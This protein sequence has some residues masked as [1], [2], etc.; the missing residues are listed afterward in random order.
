MKF[1]NDWKSRLKKK[2]DDPSEVLAFLQFLFFKKVLISWDSPVGFLFFI[3][4]LFQ[5]TFT[6]ES[7]PVTKILVM[8]YTLFQHVN[9]VQLK[10]LLLQL[11]YISYLKRQFILWKLLQSLNFFSR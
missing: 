11:E 5:S 10:E 7:L 6:G 8:E 1:A 2:R 3:F 9:K 4:F